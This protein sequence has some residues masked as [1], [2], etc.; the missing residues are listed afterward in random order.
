MDFKDVASVSSRSSSSF[1]NKNIRSEKDTSKKS[2]NKSSSK[3]QKASEGREGFKLSFLASAKRYGEAINKKYF[4][5][6][7]RSKDTESSNADQAMDGKGSV[8]LRENGK[9]K[10]KSRPLSAL[11]LSSS[12]S[13]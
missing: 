4:A 10:P 1:N 5:K 7:P 3:K 13:K 12:L 6:S 11:L 8:R 2:S 9:N